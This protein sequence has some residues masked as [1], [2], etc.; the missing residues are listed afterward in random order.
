MGER[1]AG[2]GRGG[3]RGG[4]AA[5]AAAWVGTGRAAGGARVEGNSCGWGSGCLR[6]GK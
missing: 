6:F 1:G 5:P 4:A 2:G 3:G